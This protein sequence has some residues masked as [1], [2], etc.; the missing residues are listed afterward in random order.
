MIECPHCLSVQQV[1]PITVLRPD[2]K[3]LGDLMAGKLNLV[4]CAECDSSFPLNVPILFRDDD[5]SFLIYLLPLEDN[6][7]WETAE[8]QVARIAHTV[9]GQD[10]SSAPTC[11]L[12]LMHRDFIEK[13]AIHQRGLDDRIIEYVKF[14]L[15]KNPNFAG[16]L[17]PVRH[18]LLFDFSPAADDTVSFIVFDRE[19]SDA[20]AG[21]HL[22][23]EDYLEVEKTFFGNIKLKAEFEALFPGHYV[24][25]DRLLDEQM[26]L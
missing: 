12:V 20:T 23:M 10:S 14:Q 24:S 22:A 6:T 4:Q 25:V 13:I 7:E 15:Y 18:R 9:F 2:D 11:R 26:Q 8:K 16:E 5:S 19:S 17:D 3:A 21:T 1:C